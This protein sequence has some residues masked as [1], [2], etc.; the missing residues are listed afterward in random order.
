MPGRYQQLSADHIIA[1]LE[2]LHARILARFPDAGLARVCAELIETGR[3]SV[4]E[5]AALRQR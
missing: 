2:K 3:A 4:A 5:A 1:T